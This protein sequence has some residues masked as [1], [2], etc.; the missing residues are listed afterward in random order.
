MVIGSQLRRY[1]RAYTED[2]TSAFPSEESS[3]LDRYQAKD[4]STAT[5]EGPRRRKTWPY[6]QMPVAY[7]SIHF[8]ANRKQRLPI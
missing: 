7:A 4:E 3:I 2:T 8:R 6:H 1:G 5:G